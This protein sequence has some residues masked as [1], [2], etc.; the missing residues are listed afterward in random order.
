[1]WKISLVGL[2]L[3]FM[4]ADRTAAAAYILSVVRCMLQILSCSHEVKKLFACF[5]SKTFF[6]FYSDPK[7]A[8]NVHNYLFQNIL[9]EE[10]YLWC[11]TV[12]LFVFT[13]IRSHQLYRTQKHVKILTSMLHTFCSYLYQW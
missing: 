1:M 10:K 4:T 9:D 7:N 12:I 3:R 6:F 5:C 13:D 2:S 11:Y 8:P